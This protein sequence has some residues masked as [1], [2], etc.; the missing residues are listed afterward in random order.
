[1]LDLVTSAPQLMENVREL[2]QIGVAVTMGAAQRGAVAA[3]AGGAVGGA[4]Q[5]AAVAAAGQ[6]GVVGELLAMAE[7]VAIEAQDQN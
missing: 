5:E 2:M 1:M 6:E 7:S 3:A 4:T